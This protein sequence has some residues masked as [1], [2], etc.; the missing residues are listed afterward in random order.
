VQTSIRL[1]GSIESSA[2]SLIASDV[3]GIVTEVFAEEGDRVSKGDALAQLRKTELELTLKRQTAELAESRARLALLEK[4]LARSQ[5]LLNRKSISE[6]KFDQT[7]YDVKAGQ[8]RVE[9]L[10]ADLALTEF[11]IA[12]STITAPFDGVIVDRQIQVGEWRD[13]GE[14]HFEILSDDR[15][16]VHLA[17]PEQYY[18]GVA[19]GQKAELR[20]S[21][22]AGLTLP[23]TVKAIVPRADALARTFLVKLSVDDGMEQLVAG[24][25]AEVVL[26]VGESQTSILVP[27]DAVITQGEETVVFVISD[28]D[29]AEQVNVITH[30]SMGNWQVVEGPLVS[31]QKTVIRGN[32]SLAPGQAV[33]AEELELDRP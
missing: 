18:A 8:V 4:D 30:Q 27:K 22:L 28:D 16:E 26:Y 11:Y 13:Q 3:E 24:M 29:T 10:E 21:S 20:F 12:N 17:V 23:A 2:V 1:P 7:E 6:Q 19:L 33:L 9:T 5:E 15:L 14:T 31:G 32:E 25:L